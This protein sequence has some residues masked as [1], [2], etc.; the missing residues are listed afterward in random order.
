M[1]PQHLR[2]FFVIY[3]A[4]LL[5]GAV[6]L[7]GGGHGPWIVARSVAAPLSNTSW[8]PGVGIIAFWYL[9]AELLSYRTAL[10]AILL[11]LAHYMGL[12]SV[13]FGSTSEGTGYLTW[14]MAIAEAPAFA[15]PII[16]VYLAGQAVAWRAIVARGTPAS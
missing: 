14:K 10:P 5:M 13:L 8:F 12:V 11:L 1:K 4:V 3:G 2:L 15:I 9:V 16:V 6:L 7:S